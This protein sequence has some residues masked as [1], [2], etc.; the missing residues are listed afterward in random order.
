MTVNNPK[1]NTMSAFTAQ[2]T[3]IVDGVVTDVSEAPFANKQNA[4][5][6]V[7]PFYKRSHNQ[8]RTYKVRVIRNSDGVVVFA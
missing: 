4:I 2:I 3:T 8:Y 5:S 7:Y 6:F 1:G